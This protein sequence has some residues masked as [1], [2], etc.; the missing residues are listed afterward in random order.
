M[1]SFT[2]GLSIDQLEYNKKLWIVNK[3]FEYHVGS[4]DSHEIIYV[5]EGFI[6]DGASIPRFLWPIVGHPLGEY[7]QS[8]VLHDFILKDE[9][10]P[11][12]KCDRVFLESLKVLGVNPIKR[13]I[14]YWGV[15][16]GS[17][18][19]TVAKKLKP[20]RKPPKNPTI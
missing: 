12:K 3:A 13:R 10:Y 2:K 15:R 18:C 20:V 9:I 5:P 8:A 4:E 6:T 17:M 16:L 7:A 19:S 1:S 11:R 14:M